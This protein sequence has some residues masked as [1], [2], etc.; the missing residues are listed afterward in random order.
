[1]TDKQGSTEI[2][3]L[4][5]DIIYKRR[6]VRRFTDE[7]VSEED[8]KMIVE[9]A[10]WAPSGENSQGWRFVII[11]DKEIIKKLGEISG[12]GSARRFTGEFVSKRLHKRFSGLQDEE[13]KKKAFE[14][15][16][17]GNVSRFVSTAPVVIAV[18]GKKD[19]WDVQLDN[20]AAI[21]NMLIMVSALGLG[22]TWVIAPC[23]DIR[24]EIEVNKL[25]GVTKDYKVISII[26][27]GHME[28]LP[29][30]RP[31][32]ELKEIT[33]ENKMGTPYFKE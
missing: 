12:Y 11:K 29:N 24:D 4:V 3:D 10:R 14:K 26:P 6:S 9:A 27:I 17:S 1:M 21:E 31:R 2:R 13:K 15:L 28:R 18:V 20:A 22:A 32:L 23:T 7:P 33:F 8:L 5:M 16:M 30:P 25:L 19:V